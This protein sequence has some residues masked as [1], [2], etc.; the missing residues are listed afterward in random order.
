M[1]PTCRV[2]AEG[3]WMTLRRRAWLGA[4]LIF[5]ISSSPIAFAQQEVSVRDLNPDHY[6]VAELAFLVPR[7][8]ELS[9]ILSFRSLGSQ[10]SLA[11]DGWTS[12]SFAQYAAG[13]LTSYGYECLIATEGD[14]SWI[15]AD[16]ALSGSPVWIP[17][18]TLPADGEPFSEIGTIPMSRDSGGWLFFDPAFVG[19]VDTRSPGDN[20]SPTARL[21]APNPPGTTGLILR[22]RALAATDPDGE[23][24]VFH[25]DFGDGTYLAYRD[26]QVATH[27][28][29][30]HGL[31]AITLRVIDNHGGCGVFAYELL[32]EDPDNDECIPCAEAQAE[33]SAEG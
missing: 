25:W 14:Q 24:L 6:T 16:I 8:V 31:Y 28:Y 21:R 11:N 18:Q 27:T 26:N 1:N 23:I 5:L 4:L 9:D 19:A 7:V 3:Q 13:V 32:V 30:Q 22:F 17:I 15:L 10:Q 12:E 29:T 20:A 33:K 2:S